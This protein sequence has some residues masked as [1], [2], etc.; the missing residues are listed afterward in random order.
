M[1]DK[2]ERIADGKVPLKKARFLKVTI[3]RARQLAGLNGY[4]TNLPKT[5]MPGAAVIN[6]YHDLWQVE[7]HLTILLAALGD[8]THLQDATGVT[9]K[10]LAR[11]LKP[12][13]TLTV[14]TGAQTITAAPTIGTEVR[15]V[16]DQLPPIHAP[17][18]K[19]VQLGSRKRDGAH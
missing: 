12:L 5:C 2:A 8:R 9:I 19:P 4:A 1:I 6:A 17:G 16:L 10:W 14:H 13:R 7:A 15:S 11:T 3:D 18:P